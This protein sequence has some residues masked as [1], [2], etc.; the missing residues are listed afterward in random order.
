[1]RL[2]TKLIRYIFLLLALIALNSC[3]EVTTETIIKPTASTYHT[4]LTKTGARKSNSIRVMSFNILAPCWAS[5]VYYPE[6][7]APLLNRLIRR[8]T[9]IDLLKNNQS[10]VDVFALQEVSQIEFNYIKE[11]LSLTHIGF[12]ANHSP[13]YWLNWITSD[14]PWELNGNAIFVKR[15]R[16]STVSFEDFPA[17]GSGNHAALFTGTIKNADGRTV[18]IASVHLDSDHA[19]NRKNEMSAVLTKWLPLNNS[20]DIIAGDFNTETD[21]TNIQSDLKK[22]GYFDL[23]EI[24]G[25]AEQTH[26]W[27]SKYYGAD[28]WG[29]IDHIVSRGSTPVDGSVMNFNLFNLYPNDEEMRINRNLQL[30]GSDH[31][32][33]TGTMSY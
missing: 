3:T 29:I 27:T 19:Y 2:N 1:M 32:P 4:S 13:A 11:A 31:F 26:P 25:K 18:R 30:S 33:I 23:L 12:Q 14:I 17:S 7:T 9:I 21:A 16:F 24:L 10:T 6:S 22:A 28:N 5:S 20:T 8:Q 15:D